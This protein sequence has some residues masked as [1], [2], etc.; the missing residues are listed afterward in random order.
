MTL[1]FERGLGARVSRW[2]S[3]LSPGWC[4]AGDMFLFPLLWDGSKLLQRVVIQIAHVCVCC[5]HLLDES[6]GCGL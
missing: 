4:L 1:L 2:C 5:P 3:S 6:W